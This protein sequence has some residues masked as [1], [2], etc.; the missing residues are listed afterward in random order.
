[1]W[2]IECKA[3]MAEK[4]FN[5]FCQAI[6]QLLSGES[7]G[8][9]SSTTQGSLDMIHRWEKFAENCPQPNIIKNANI[10]YRNWEKSKANKNALTG[11]PQNIWTKYH[12]VKV[13][14]IRESE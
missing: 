13:K 7:I 2:A 10:Y 1:M 14:I 3:S 8:I 6:P 9:M 4:V 12:P 11:K 5:Q